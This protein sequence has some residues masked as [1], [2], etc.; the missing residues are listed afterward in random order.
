M[1]NFLSAWKN[2]QPAVGNDL[3]LAEDRPAFEIL[4]RQHGVIRYNSWEECCQGFTLGSV[5]AAFMFACCRCHLLV[6]YQIPA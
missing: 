4:E 2:W 5:A 3:I 6:I 1:D